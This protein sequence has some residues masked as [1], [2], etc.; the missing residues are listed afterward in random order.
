MAIEKSEA[1]ILRVIPFRDTSKIVTAYTAEHGLVSLLA[2]G[3]RAAKPRFGAA[4]ELF[5]LA[6]LVYYQKDSRELQLLSQ[7]TLLEPHLGLADDP[8]RYAFG[9]A[10]LE[11][12]LK[13]LAGQEPPGRLYPLALRTLEVLEEADPGALL[14]V[15]RAFELKAVSFLGHRPEL[16]ACVECQGSVENGVGMG[17]SALLGGVLCA[18]CAG[19]V[20]GTMDLTGPT[21][22]LMRRFLTATLAGIAEAPP[23]PSETAALG[24]ILEPFLQAHL[25]R[26]EHLR[27]LRL[28]QGMKGQPT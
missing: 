24:R 10:V 12:L 2:K 13:V 7:A 11:F 27:A 9:V 6:D 3:V 25:E 19:S 18:R 16:Y 28:A 23:G 4:L 8:R 26:Y 17:F 15:F 5:A 21:L 14:S 20:P 1:L 22:S